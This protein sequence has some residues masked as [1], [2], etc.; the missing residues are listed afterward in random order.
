MCVCL[1]SWIY[2]E[3]RL[4]FLLILFSS[5]KKPLDSNK[6]SETNNFS[7]SSF[8]PKSGFFGFLKSFHIPINLRPISKTKRAFDPAFWALSR[9][10]KKFFQIL[11]RFE[12]ALDQKFQKPI[13]KGWLI[14]I[15]KKVD[16]FWRG[17]KGTNEVEAFLNLTWL[18][19][20][21]T[22]GS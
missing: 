5:M 4:F 6:S 19:S 15:D 20:N 22:I 3:K 16:C 18:R 21:V 10:F 17:I 12:M 13:L 14:L 8:F 7:K 1:S 9:L 2:T 11:L